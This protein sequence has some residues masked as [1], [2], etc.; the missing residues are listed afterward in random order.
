MS[1][2]QHGWSP[3]LNFHTWTSRGQECVELGSACGSLRPSLATACLCE[4]RVTRTYPHPCSYVLLLVATFP[5]T[6]FSSCERDQMACKSKMSLPSYDFVQPALEEVQGLCSVLQ[7]A[8]ALTTPPHTLSLR[9]S[10]TLGRGDRHILPS[11]MTLHLSLAFDPSGALEPQ[12][13][14]QHELQWAG[15]HKGGPE[16][17]PAISQGS[18]T[19]PCRLNSKQGVGREE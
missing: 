19:R 4:E 18:H 3:P 12:T 15:G 7:A 11:G 16:S 17:G 13:P 9:I 1:Y 10:T 6:A 5:A 8:P 2:L 14:R